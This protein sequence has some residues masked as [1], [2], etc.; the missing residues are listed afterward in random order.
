[1]VAGEEAMRQSAR[2][3]VGVGDVRPASVTVAPFIAVTV[4][5]V[6]ADQAVHRVKLVG[7]DVA[8]DV[9]P[10]TTEERSLPGLKAGMYTV[11]VDG[12]TAAASLVVGDEA[13]P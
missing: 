1:M 3:T 7:T 11:S 12:G 4:A 10:G 13:A 5:V 6:N 8:F 9:P 2:F